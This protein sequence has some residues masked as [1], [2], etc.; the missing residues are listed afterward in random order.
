[1]YQGKFVFAQIMDRVP[2]Q[3]FQACVDR[4]RG[5]RNIQ[6]F[7]CTDYFRVMAFAPLAGAFYVMDRGY[8]D[9]E[10]LYK[11]NQAK[12]FFVTRANA[13]DKTTGVQ[14]DQAIVMTN[15]PAFTG[16]LVVQ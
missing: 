9:F 4:Y 15:P 8:L 1:M 14:C 2:W 10:R 12:A 7:K 6:T 16:A 13:V 11:I 5:D 3:R